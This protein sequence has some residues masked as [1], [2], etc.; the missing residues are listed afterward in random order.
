MR[1][2]GDGIVVVE[3]LVRAFRTR[4]VVDHHEGAVGP[5]VD[6]IGLAP[7]PHDPPV[8]EGDLD[9]GSVAVGH[10]ER[11]LGRERLGCAV[12]PVGL[13]GVEERVELGEDEAPVAVPQ[14]AAARQPLRLRARAHL[15]CDLAEPVV[16]VGAPRPPGVG[17]RPHLVDE[18]VEDLV[19]DIPAFDRRELHD[20]LGSFDRIDVQHRLHEV[21]V[22]ARRP[23]LQ[24]GRRRD[25]VGRGR[26]D[27]G[28]A[29][30]RDAR[31]CRRS[32]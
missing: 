28:E 11:Q 32:G 19:H 3:R 26:A 18:A 20:V 16:V 22:R 23:R 12:G 15:F 9:R 8:A 6:A 4:L 13:V 1:A 29:V 27:R 30:A 14:Q 10:A 7:H 21:R 5:A 31:G 2:R 17:T 24:P 25:A